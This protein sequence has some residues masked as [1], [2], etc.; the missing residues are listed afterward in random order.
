MDVPAQAYEAVAR[1]EAREY[2]NCGLTSQP[3]AFANVWH[4]LSQP[5]YDKIQWLA[6]P[7]V[8]LDSAT[9]SWAWYGIGIPA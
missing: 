5:P 3:D 9:K 4:S 6:K 2:G 1:G 7:T 8:F